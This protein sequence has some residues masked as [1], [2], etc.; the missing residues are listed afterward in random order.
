MKK[1]FEKIWLIIVISFFIY[2]GA[3]SGDWGALFQAL[4]EVHLITII[5]IAL[6]IGVLFT[7]NRRKK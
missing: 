1:I 3:S 7:I 4:F 6:I 5:V 2:L